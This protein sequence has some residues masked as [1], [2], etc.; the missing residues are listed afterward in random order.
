LKTVLVDKDAVLVDVGAV[1]PER[2]ILRVSLELDIVLW[3]VD[4][5]GDF[6]AS[7][8]RKRIGNHLKRNVV[9][10]SAS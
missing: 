8:F 9:G 4:V 10:R 3:V 7:T 5:V 2:S 6:E 1:I